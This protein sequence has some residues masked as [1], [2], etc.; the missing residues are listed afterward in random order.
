MDFN[1]TDTYLQDLEHYQRFAREEIAP[2][3]RQMEQEGATPQALLDKMAQAQLLGI[4]MPKE[5]GGLGKDFI[6]ATL[7]M[8][9]LAKASPATAGIINVSTELV[10]DNILRHGTEEQK[11][12][13]LPDLCT[14]KVI[15]A[16]ALTEPGAGSDASGVRTVAEDKGDHWLL[17]GTKCF[18]TNAEIAGTFLIAAMTDIGEGKKKISM[19]IVEK[20]FS[21]FRIG[22]HENKMGIRSSSTCELILEDCVVPKENLL[23]QKGKGLGIALGCL[24]SGRVMIA[25]QA[26]GIAQACWDDTVA[27][28]KEHAQETGFAVN[29][30]RTQFRLAEL[31]TKI[32]AAR[33]LIYR[34]AAAWSEGKKYGKEAAMAKYYASDVANEATRL[35]LEL[36]GLDGC[37]CGTRLE[38]YFRDA[39]ITEIYEGTNEIQLMVIA[40]QLDIKV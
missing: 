40:G 33:L 17:N 38:E 16:F 3:F 6:S 29:T 21:G 18:I 22:K 27:Y 1:L 28:L 34:A 11:A 15:G 30:Q 14:G 4:P 35:C 7:C 26:L 23:G 36:T 12:K 9:T 2:R 32:D 37:T 5:Y 13:Y 20:G 24:D 39:K 19:F 25:A 31:Q 8:E 10:A